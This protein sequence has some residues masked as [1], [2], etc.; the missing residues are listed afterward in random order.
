MFINAHDQITDSV[1]PL[2]QIY[3]SNTIFKD[4]TFSSIGTRPCSCLKLANV[5]LTILQSSFTSLNV[6]NDFECHSF[7]LYA[8][9]SSIEIK[10]TS[11]NNIQGKSI[12]PYYGVVITATRNIYKNNMTEN[13]IVVMASSFIAADGNFHNRAIVFS[14]YQNARIQNTLF[15]QNNKGGAILSNTLG[16]VY[17][18]GSN[19]TKNGFITND[20]ENAGGHGGALLNKRGNVT[21]VSSIFNSNE[22]DTH[23]LISSGGAIYNVEGETNKMLIN[24]TVFV[25]NIADDGADLLNS[26]NAELEITM[27]KFSTKLLDPNQLKG[28]F[29]SCAVKPSI[30][31]TR[32]CE[33]TP[34]GAHCKKKK[35]FEI[36]SV[37]ADQTNRYQLDIEWRKDSTFQWKQEYS[38][39]NTLK[40][41]E[42]QYKYGDMHKIS[43]GSILIS[44]RLKQAVEI[45]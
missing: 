11:F 19:F 34:V 35:A 31:N 8:E 9:D 24:N 45:Q 18:S 25:G 16:N 23:H 3:I 29:I 26:C 14:G 42:I 30:C 12:N 7:G 38:N 15:F 21:I 20:A 5:K 32:W 28:N 6:A 13:S 4:N 1:L 22:V 36:V 2:S 40:Q 43:S 17:I 10:N 39:A 37:L 33:T 44:I 41:V 27:S